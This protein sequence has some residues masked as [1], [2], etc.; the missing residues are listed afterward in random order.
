[1]TRLAHLLSLALFLVAVPVK[2]QAVDAAA[3]DRIMAASMSQ[4]HVPGAALAVVENDKVVYLKAYGVKELGSGAP[5]TPDTL[6]NIASMTKAFTATAMAML[7]DEGKL[8]W[9]D[10]VR[11]HL[12]YFRLSDPCADSMVTLRDLLSHRT[13]LVGYDALWDDSLL[14]REEIIRRMASARP[15]RAFRSTYRYNNIMFIA[16]GEAVAAAAGRSWD[17]FVQTRLLDPLGMTETRLTL[18]GYTASDHAIGY[19]WDGSTAAVTPYGLVDDS[20][21]GPAGAIKS[22]ARDMAQWVRFHLANGIIDGKRLVS[23]EALGETK[24]P[25]SV[26]RLGPSDQTAGTPVTHLDS[27][28]MGWGLQD[29]RGELLVTHGGALNGFRGT[30]ALL[31]EH[32]LGFVIL[33]NLGRSGAVTA[34]RNALLD[35]LLGTRDLRDWNALLLEEDRKSEAK[36]E[37]AKRTLLASRVP[38]TR[39]SHDLA[40][41]AGTYEEPVFGAAAVTL[42]GDHLVLRWQRMAIPLEHFHY[43][44]FRAVSPQ[45]DLDDQVTFRTGADGTIA[46]MTFMAADFS[47]RVA[48]S[49]K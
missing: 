4:W 10:P 16:A 23:A 41:Y 35:L 11:K 47:R 6:F 27:Y 31:P 36:A 1:M 37:T 39:P 28:A 7:V 46:G 22:S 34:M 25:N 14:G 20:N 45:D 24:Q 21:L 48:K 15:A 2:A 19:R 42:E 49:A 8:D 26:V 38:D 12:P 44:T 43:D 30:V 13:G 3:I 5:V 33:D 18:A 29:Y 17:S 32:N 40:A 9:D